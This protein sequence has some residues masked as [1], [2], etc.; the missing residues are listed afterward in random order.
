MPHSEWWGHHDYAQ[1]SSLFSLRLPPVA[2]PPE[3]ITAH[4][5][6]RSCWSL[7]PVPHTLERHL[8]SVIVECRESNP[9]PP[10]CR[11]QIGHELRQL[12]NG[13]GYSLVAITREHWFRPRLRKKT[14]RER[15]I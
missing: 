15:L 11:S 1:S 14:V 7:K 5:G 8:G 6:A 12:D 2:I 10:R 4:L 13:F 3:P 9:S